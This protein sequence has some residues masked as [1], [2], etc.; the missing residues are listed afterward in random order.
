MA[1]VKSGRAEVEA[2]VY[3]H[4][5]YDIV[6]DERIVVRQPDIMIVEGLNVLQSTPARAPPEAPRVFVSDFFDFSIY[7]DAKRVAHPAVVREPVPD[8]AAHGVR[9]PEVVLPPLRGR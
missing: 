3:S 1:D 4:L 6:P 9:E 5:R 8:A 2:P 7:V